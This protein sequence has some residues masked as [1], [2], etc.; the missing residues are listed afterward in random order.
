[1]KSILYT[2]ISRVFKFSKAV[3]FAKYM[4]KLEKKTI[5][6][7]LLLQI[8]YMYIKY[9]YKTIKENNNKK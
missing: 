6:H 9:V 4:F 3:K 5:K 1:M 8:L 2:S 7:I